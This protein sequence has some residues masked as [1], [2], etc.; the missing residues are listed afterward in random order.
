M[1]PTFWFVV[2]SWV[3]QRWFVWFA[4]SRRA[5]GLAKVLVG[6]LF[7]AQSVNQRP[8]FSALMD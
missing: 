3:R 6:T 5:V 1:P 2:D 8:M 7:V 4:R